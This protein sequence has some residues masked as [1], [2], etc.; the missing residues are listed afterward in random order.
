MTNN[1]QF[2]SIRQQYFTDGTGNNIPGPVFAAFQ[3]I[4]VHLKRN[5]RDVAP[6]T[7]ASTLFLIV[8]MQKIGENLEKLVEVMTAKAA[9]AITDNGESPTK[10]AAA[11]ALTA[12]KK[13]PAK[14]KAA[15]KKKTTAKK[16][17]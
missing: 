1:G 10:K 4:V 5:Y 12:K 13:A 17:K 8:T 14:K 9:P 3:D 2:D 16:K 15:P 6:N 7:T 11:K